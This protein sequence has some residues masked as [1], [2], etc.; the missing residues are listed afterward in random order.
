[1]INPSTVNCVDDLY[2]QNILRDL[3][4]LYEAVYLLEYKIETLS[5]QEPQPEQTPVETVANL[6]A[7]TYVDKINASAVAATAMLNSK[8]DAIMDEL[9]IYV[10]KIF[11][12]IDMEAARKAWREDLKNVAKECLLEYKDELKKCQL[13]L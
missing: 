12:D 3:K 8:K 9:K 11:T 13:P 5:C 7:D 2:P 10:K 1:M 4:S 6:Q